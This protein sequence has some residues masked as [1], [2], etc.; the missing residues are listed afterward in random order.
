MPG[1]D[2]NPIFAAAFAAM[3]DGDLDGE[4][5][6]KSPASKNTCTKEA[7]VSEDYQAH[8]DFV[9]REAVAAFGQPATPMRQETLGKIPPEELRARRQ[10]NPTMLKIVSMDLSSVFKRN[11]RTTRMI[12][13]TSCPLLLRDDRVL[14]FLDLFGM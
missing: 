1:S 7:P 11:T 12:P 13:G 4:E 5:D 3:P 8:L 2:T 14:S 10:S 9:V 6:R